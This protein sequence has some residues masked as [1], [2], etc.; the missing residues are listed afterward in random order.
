MGTGT[1]SATRSQEGSRWTT[2]LLSL[3]VLIIAW[4]LVAEFLNV[5][6]L[7]SPMLVAAYSYELLV[8]LEW[9]SHTAVSL[10]RMFIAFVVSTIL[11]VA[12]ALLLGVTSFWEEVIKD[13]VV[14]G[15]TMP[16]LILII[17]A[18]MVFGTS[19]LTPIVAA[20]IITLPSTIQIV[21]EAVKDIDNDLIEMARAF[22]VSRRSILYRIALK[23][24]LPAVFVAARL[25]IG[26]IF[27]VVSLGE[28]I[29]TSSGLGFMIRVQLGRT[30][31]TGLISWGLIIV[32]IIMIVEYGIFAQLEKRLFDYRQ[33]T[34]KGDI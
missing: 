7:S 32:A 21:Y 15:L 1:G 16:G 9:V 34:S 11:G 8:S 24:V 5:E 4:Y 25:S 13:Y 30:S 12:I 19:S 31:F 33:E 3:V 10:W 17:F 2:T 28:Y 27:T 18:A 26:G 20:T 6:T 23:S 22:D 14:I 29:A